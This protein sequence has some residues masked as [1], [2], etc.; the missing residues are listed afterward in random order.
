M[1]AQQGEILG[2]ASGDRP[3]KY[4]IDAEMAEERRRSLPVMIASR[5]CYMCQQAVDEEEPE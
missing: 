2:G 4:F 5:H 3:A 1:S